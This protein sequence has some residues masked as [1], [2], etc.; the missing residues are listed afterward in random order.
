M[1]I[2]KRSAALLAAFMVFTS[3]AFAASAQENFDEAYRSLITDGRFF[4]EVRYRYENVEQD[5]FA[6]EANANTFRANI[7]FQ[8]GVYRNFQGLAEF[9]VIQDIG[10]ENFNSTTN[11]NTEFPVVADPNA[12]EFNRAWVTWTG[13]PQT[14]VRVGRQKINLD[15]QRFVG[16]VNWRQNDQTFDGVYLE[17][18]S[19]ENL[20]LKYS[21]VRNVNRIFG[22]DGR[23]GDLDSDVHIFNASYAATDWLKVTG[24]AYLFDFDLLAARSSQTYGLRATGKTKVSRDWSFLYELEA[25]TQSDYEDNPSSFDDEYYH[26]V[27]GVKGRGLT[28]KAGY[29]EL[30]GD[31][32]N[33]FQTP[34][35]TLHKFNGWADIFL[36]TP[37]DGLQDAYVSAAYKV[38]GTNT[39]LDGTTFKAVYHDFDSDAGNVD[40]F[41]EELDLLIGKSF[42]VPGLDGWSFKKVNVLLKYAD[43]NGGGGFGDKQKFWVQVGFKF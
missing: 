40:D 30:G 15:N 29:E 31:G 34:L 24:Y 17:N 42:D 1:R 35:A 13:L 19:V 22:E 32:T 4:G 28:L 36:T 25:A 39:L 11:G 33:A 18:S 5:G 27:A 6:S 9:Q 21:Y 12:T 20:D 2:Q 3:P 37:A 16:T 43:Y 7:G 23:L 10:Q 38:G 41:G 26:A 8:T 14:S